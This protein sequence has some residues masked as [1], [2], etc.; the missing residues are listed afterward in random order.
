MEELARDLDPSHGDVRAKRSAFWTMLV[1]SSVIVACGV[2]TDSTATVIGAMIIAPL[3]TPIMGIA[4]GSVRHRR[5]GAVGVVVLACLLVVAV[6]MVFSA[7]LPGDYDLLSNGQIA[8]RTSP[9]LLDLVAAVATG[10]AGAVAQARRDVAAVLPGVAI[11]ISLV[12]PLVVAGV[13]L[14]DGAGWLALGA[15]VL[16]LSNLFALVFGGMV[17]FAAL[18][19]GAEAAGT[20]GRPVRRTYLAMALLF[21]VV[22]VP[23]AAN[24]AL[25]LLLDTWT[26]RAKDAAGQWLAGVQGAYVTN[27][28]TASRTMYIHVRV[29]GNPPPVE[30][31]LDRL[32]GQVPDGVP[33][34]VETTNGR[35]IDAGRVGGA[36]SG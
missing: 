33:I 11:A 32:D 16:F 34:V 19:Y 30:R 9:G 3:S 14:G 17:V 7:V 35:R 21:T 15:L 26:G 10:L 22:F 27:V 2:L 23:L 6:G 13:C 28:D 36:G 29:P 25:T 31:L 1:L 20:A 5:T 18:G 8:G 4:L 24:T 12:P